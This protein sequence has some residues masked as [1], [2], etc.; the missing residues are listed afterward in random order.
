MVTHL[1]VGEHPHDG[2]TTTVAQRMKHQVQATFRAP[3]ASGCKVDDLR[4][5]QV[6]R[7]LRNGLFIELPGLAILVE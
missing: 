7:V 3:D 4:W 1:A 5:R 6:G 2:A